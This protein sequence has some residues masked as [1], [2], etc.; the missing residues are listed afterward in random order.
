[1]KWGTLEIHCGE[2]TVGDFDPSRVG[3]L[4]QLGLEFEAGLGGCVGDQVDYDLVA[5]QWSTAPVLSNVTEHAMLDLVP[6]AGA[7]R[8]MTDM[9]RH[10]QIDGHFMERDFPHATTAAVAATSIGRDQQLLGIAIT[11]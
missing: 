9:N 5:H 11:L 2:F 8:K 10:A 3:S 6:L 1:M 7:R 4:I